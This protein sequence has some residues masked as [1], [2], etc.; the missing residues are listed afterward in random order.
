MRG[1]WGRADLQP[2]TIETRPFW[3]C[4]VRAATLANAML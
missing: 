1:L 3:P 2:A 4:D